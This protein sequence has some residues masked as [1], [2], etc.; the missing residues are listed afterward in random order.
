MSQVVHQAGAYSVFCSTKRVFLLPLDGMLS[1]T[2]GI[3]F[4]STQ[5]YTPGWRKALCCVL[6]KEH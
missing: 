6:A 5:V 3:K 1:V 2:P 4:A